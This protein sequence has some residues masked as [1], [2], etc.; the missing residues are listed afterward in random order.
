MHCSKM[1]CSWM[2]GIS[3]ILMMVAA[4]CGDGDGGDGGDDV[5]KF[6]FQ[7]KTTT[8]ALMEHFQLQL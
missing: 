8:I 1:Q 6:G 2:H 3:M 7:C 4:K 5:G